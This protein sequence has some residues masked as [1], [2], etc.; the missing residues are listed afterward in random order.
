MTT[1]TAFLQHSFVGKATQAEPYTASAHLRYIFRRDAAD[2]VYTEH[3][4]KQYHAAQRF[5][6]RHE[7]GLRKNG[8]VIDKFIISI[9]R[10]VD[11]DHAAFALKRFGYRLGKGRTP[12]AFAIHGHGESNYHAHFLFIDRDVQTGKRV[13]QTTARNS[14]KGIKMEWET[15]ANDTF[16]Q[17]GYEWRVQVKDG[18]EAAND[19]PEPIPEREDTREGEDDVVAFEK[20]KPTLEFPKNED[21][22]DAGNHVLN[23]RETAYRQEELEKARQKLR[24]AEERAEA[25]ELRRQAAEHAAAQHIAEKLMPAEQ[26]LYRSEQEL[27]GHKTASGKL[28]GFGLNVFGWE[29]KTSARK[30]AE[31]A[32]STTEADKMDFAWKQREQREYDFAAHTA[33]QEAEAASRHA[34]L[35]RNSLI[36]E[37]GSLKAMDEVE[38]IYA[39]TMEKELAELTHEQVMEALMNGEITVEDVRLYL[40]LTGREVELKALEQGYDI[41][42]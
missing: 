7:D 32:V 12:F 1:L 3:M 10:G 24:D 11:L 41:I 39:N 15:A 30:A 4:P 27:E 19:N 38:T 9:P 2:L 17:L 37:Y 8:R 34:I 18:I 33:V 40:I 21:I 28:K 25:A 35:Y 16:A 22:S 14:T 23:V 20:F 42:D 29:L 13:F 5:L 26:Q 31:Q 36:E 6:D